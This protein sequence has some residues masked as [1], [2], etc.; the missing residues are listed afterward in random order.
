MEAD[1]ENSLDH[2]FISPGVSSRGVLTPHSES[3]GGY[4]STIFFANTQAKSKLNL[5]LAIRLIL[6]VDS[7]SVTPY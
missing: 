4:P 7:V 1:R 3:L 2:L 6:I 5:K